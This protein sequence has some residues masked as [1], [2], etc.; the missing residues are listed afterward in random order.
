MASE[1]NLLSRLWLAAI[2]EPPLQDPRV[3]SRQ[4][5]RNRPPLTPR[6]PSC[7]AEATGKSQRLSGE[8]HSLTAAPPHYTGGVAITWSRGV[9]CEEHHVDIWIEGRRSIELKVRLTWTNN[10]RGV[11]QPRGAGHPGP[12]MW[13]SNLKGQRVRRPKGQ[14]VG[15]GH[16]KEWPAPSDAWRTR[17]FLTSHTNQPDHKGAVWPKPSQADAVLALG[18]FRVMLLWSQSTRRSS[19]CVSILF[20]ASFSRCM[21]KS[22]SHVYF[23]SC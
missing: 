3:K 14:R 13:M 12:G 19:T 18:I 2:A 9:P 21:V 1:W 7:W 6:P 4:L 16:P 22:L 8:S 5:K 15:P 11:W 23:T 10:C 20:Y 17:I